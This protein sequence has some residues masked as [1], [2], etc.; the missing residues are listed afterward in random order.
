VCKPNEKKKKRYRKE[1]KKS[2][3]IEEEEAPRAAPQSRRTTCI[4]K[5]DS[6]G[7]QV[8]EVFGDQKPRN[9]GNN[10]HR[11]WGVR[12]LDHFY[13]ILLRLSS[14]CVWTRKK[15]ARSAAAKKYTVSAKST[16]WFPGFP[17][18]WESKT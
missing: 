12:T 15:C 1:G 13:D 7:S 16:V 14:L 2:I 6:F 9:L 11:I 17:R 5:I 4:S 10:H 3:R 18:F 8:F